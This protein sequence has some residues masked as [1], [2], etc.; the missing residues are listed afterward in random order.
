MFGTA[1]ALGLLAILQTNPGQTDIVRP[2]RDDPI[3]DLLQWIPATDETERGYAAWV[4]LPGSPLGVTDALD[5]LSLVPAPLALGRS[6]EFQRAVGI[7]SSQVTG[8]ASALGAG[9]T[10]LA[11]EFDH[12]Y[13]EAS[14]ALADYREETWRGVTIWS[15]AP[16]RQAPLSIEGDDLRAMNV[17]VPL[18]D[19]VLLA[20]DRSAAEAAL[21]TAV[22]EG[23]SLA[24]RSEVQGWLGNGAVAGIMVVDQRDLAV[25]C[26][27]AGS[28]TTSD[29]AGSSG[30]TVGVVYR[31]MGNETPVTSVWI[32]LADDLAAEAGV[33]SF[34]AGW[35]DGY[36]NQIG[37]GG[38]VSA[39]ASVADVRRSGTYVIADLAQGRDNGWVRSGVRFL[40]DIC[41][42]SSAMVPAG[43]PDRATLVASP[44]PEESQ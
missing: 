5:R 38:P 12:G 19:R 30:R 40:V 26:G 6:G 11:G 15:A 27:V 21:A 20:I 42:H 41:E 8:W 34:E 10:I 33:F 29:F 39:L 7:S 16:P 24:D 25:E 18:G 31:L 28:W 44:S 37:L 9:V 17:V 2:Y 32:D 22:G 36:V 14:L 23:E 43:Q 4:A 3:A 35:R 13:V 1:A